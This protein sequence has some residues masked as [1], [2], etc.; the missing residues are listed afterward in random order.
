MN[1]PTLKSC[2]F[3]GVEGEQKNDGD[4][5]FYH[6]PGC[7][8]YATNWLR[9]ASQVISWNRRTLPASIER[10]VHDAAVV[11]DN[12][13][14]RGAYIKFFEVDP[15]AISHLRDALAS[16]KKEMGK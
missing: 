7:F 1:T 10:L 3:C 16:V 12:A 8:L 9:Q 6:Q 14:E 11:L 13:H 15:V 5:H 4:Y 2:P